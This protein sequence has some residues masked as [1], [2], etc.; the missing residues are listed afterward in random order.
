MARPTTVRRKR[1]SPWKIEAT[2]I[3]N[4]RSN[5]EQNANDNEEKY[6]LLPSSD[7]N[8][9][10]VSQKTSEDILPFHLDPHPDRDIDQN[11][12]TYD[13]DYVEDET[14]TLK[15]ELEVAI[16][17]RLKAEQKLAEMEKSRNL[18]VT[19]SSVI[20]DNYDEKERKKSLVATYRKLVPRYS[21][22]KDVCTIEDFLAQFHKFV[23]TAEYSDSDIIS[24][25]G[26]YLDDE[27]REWWDYY[28]IQALPQLVAIAGT[29]EQ[30]PIV[31]RGLRDKFMPFDYVVNIT[32]KLHSLDMRKG[33]KFY[34]D[35][36]RK[37][38]QLIPSITEPEKH[39]AILA[40]LDSKQHHYLDTLG[41]Q[42]SFEILEALEKYALREQK[43]RILETQMKGAA[44][45]VIPIGKFTG[46]CH[47]CGKIGHRS[48]G[49]RSRR[50]IVNA[51]YLQ[52]GGQRK[53]FSAPN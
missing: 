16:K 18:A 34:V 45:A 5:D 24:L 6:L 52:E 53:T 44:R 15:E 35:Q 39:R 36:F 51:G 8:P 12:K 1:A 48:P 41:I 10:I 23:K 14:Q 28:H 17:A 25:F 19:K 49:C 9:F 13:E 40:K 20:T 37:Y 7:D 38:T 4:P 11:M 2:P 31:V 22:K 3:K 30:Y 21:G 50:I 42:T 26:S 47:N 27:A 32:A 43:D 29:P 33:L 46:K